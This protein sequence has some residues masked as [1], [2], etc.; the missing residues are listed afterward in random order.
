MTRKHY[1]MIAAAIFEAQMEVEDLPEREAIMHAAKILSD[2]LAQDN[3]RFNPE[4]FLAACRTD[5]VIQDSKSY[6]P[7]QPKVRL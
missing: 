2:R 4:R 1:A 5:P 7:Q 6:D 3:P